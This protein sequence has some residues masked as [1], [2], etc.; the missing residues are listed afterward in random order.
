M[1]RD[2]VKFWGSD[3]GENLP[4]RT[5][6]Q[7]GRGRFLTRPLDCGRGPGQNEVLHAFLA[8]SSQKLE[9]LIYF[10]LSSLVPACHTPSPPSS[11]SDLLSKMLKYLLIC[12]QFIFS[13]VLYL[14]SWFHSTHMFWKTYEEGG[15]GCP[16]CGRGVCHTSLEPP[17]P[18]LLTHA[19]KLTYEINS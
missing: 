19:K 5:F 11:P 14:V 4:V 2:L 18:R 13:Y 17:W 16:G 1:S 9:F 15:L 6:F 7:S 10:I 8:C 12:F 3:D